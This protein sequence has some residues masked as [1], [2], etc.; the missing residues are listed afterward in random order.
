M[1][2]GCGVSGTKSYHMRL[3]QK[4]VFRHISAKFDPIIKWIKP[5]VLAGLMSPLS[6]RKC[7]IS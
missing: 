5:A 7:E 3:R 2:N 6:T 4:A 1:M